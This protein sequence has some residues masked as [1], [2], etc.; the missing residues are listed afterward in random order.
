[1]PGLHIGGK[2]ALAL[3][4]V[5]PNLG[6]RDTLVLWGD[7]RFA[8]PVWFTSRVP[9]RYVHARL[10]DWPDDALP[11]KT[12][13]TPAGQPDGLRASIPERAV[14]ELL[15]EVGTRQSLEEARAAVP[16]L[17]PRQWAVGCG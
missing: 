7:A 6:S 5:R 9:A 12:L 3:Q 11:A 4:G 8:L 13:V 16:D 15:Y 17:G 1:M 10:F 2:S 14:L